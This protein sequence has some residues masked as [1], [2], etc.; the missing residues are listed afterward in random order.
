[1]YKIGK[2]EMVSLDL[3]T[4]QKVL[5]AIYTEYQKDLPDMEKNITTHNLG[6]ENDIFKIALNKLTNENLINGV[7]FLNGGDNPVPAMASVRYCQMTGQGIDYVEDKLD[8]KPNLSGAE[9]VAKVIEKSAGWGWDQ[10]KEMCAKTIA[11][12]VKSQMPSP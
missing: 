7:V 2:G 11:E 9:K 6:F 3:D 10:I 12:I 4:K 5:I 8:I 1:M